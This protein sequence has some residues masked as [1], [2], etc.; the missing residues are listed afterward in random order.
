MSD[1]RMEKSPYLAACRGTQTAHTPIWLNRQAGRYMP[2][3]RQLK[4]GMASLE[5]FMTPSLMAQV[6]V[7]A[8]RIL[9]V[10][11]AILFA[12]LLPML[13]PMGLDLDYVPEVGPVFANPLRSP[14]DIDRLRP[15]EASTELA[16][17]AEAVR[18]IRADLPADIPLIGFAGAP[19]TLASYAIEGQSSKQY[20]Q[21]KKFMYKAP[22]AW[23]RLMRKLVDAVAD[24]VT[25]QIDAGANSIQLFDSWVGCLSGEDFATYVLPYTQSLIERL[26]GS[27]P[28]I[29]F[30]T[31]NYHLL[32]QTMTMAIDV[33]A[34]DWRT[35]LPQTWD[36]LGCRAVQGNLD[37]V[38]LFSDWETIQHQTQSLLD[39]MGGRAGH[40]FNLG[41]G[42]MPTTPVDHVRRLVDFV[43]DYSAK[44]KQAH[45][46]A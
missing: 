30:G 34:V 33:L 12:D 25:L 37:P 18:L 16:Y 29:Y 45:P 39:A 24:Y 1:R 41:H 13:V 9:G 10:D 40:I 14:A 17:A 2:E 19:F 26:Q 44:L 20:L 43:R 35:P 27:V 6:A 4:G 31:G 46:E 11:A 5:W 22:A 21:V 42:I 28:L 15:V 7:D 36:Q 23:D 38:I 3:Y 8:Q 32:G